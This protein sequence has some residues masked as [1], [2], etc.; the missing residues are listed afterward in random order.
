MIDS[1]YIPPQLKPIFQRFITA[2]AATKSCTAQAKIECIKNDFVNVGL[3]GME[4][5]VKLTRGPLKFL[6]QRML[7]LDRVAI[8]NFGFIPKGAGP[9][10]VAIANY[11][12]SNKAEYIQQYLQQPKYILLIS[13]NL[14]AKH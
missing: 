12:L 3:P 11:V 2:I 5:G 13:Y 8:A 1:P 10:A 14:S 7:A 4:Q 9:N 6:F